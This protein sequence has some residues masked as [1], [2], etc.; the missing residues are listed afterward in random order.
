MPFAN[1]R[2]PWKC[3]AGKVCQC[4]V[5][6]TALCVTACCG[7]V[8]SLPTAC[9][10]STRQVWSVQEDFGKQDHEEYQLRR[11]APALS[12]QELSRLHIAAMLHRAACTDELP[13]SGSPPWQLGGCL[14]P[15]GPIPST[16][17][18]AAATAHRE[19]AARTQLAMRQDDAHV[20]MMHTARDCLR[21]VTGS[22][23]SH[24]P[25]AVSQ[26]DGVQRPLLDIVDLWTQ[27]K[28]GQ[29]AATVVLSRMHMMSLSQEDQKGWVKAVCNA[30]RSGLPKVAVLLP[31]GGPVDAA[32]IEEQLRT[33]LNCA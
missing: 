24:T 7:C 15:P 30:L 8:L 21:R 19:E 6:T 14:G 18:A 10:P 29:P 26:L 13:A 4:V 20:R 16:L 5:W 31:A 25:P 12:S 11:S 9:F 17:A 33:Q 23:V 32:A 3:G 2:P 1:D 28:C 27:T 22:S